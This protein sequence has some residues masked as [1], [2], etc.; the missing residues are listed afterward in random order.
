[1]ILPCVAVDSREDEVFVHGGLAELLFDLRLEDVKFVLH[2]PVNVREALLRCVVVCV[3]P[4]LI[5]KGWDHTVIE[6]LNLRGWIFSTF[7]GGWAFWAHFSHPH[8]LYL[9]L[10]CMM[11]LLGIRR[12]LLR[13]ALLLMSRWGGLSVLL[14]LLL[15]A[16]G[17]LRWCH[18]FCGRF[19][20]MINILPARTAIVIRL[21]ATRNHL[22]VMIVLRLR[23][24]CMMISIH[25]LASLRW[26]LL[27]NLLHLMRLL[28]CTTDRFVPCFAVFWR[29]LLE[30]LLGVI[31]DC[32]VS[33]W[34]LADFPVRHLL[35]LFV[36]GL[37]SFLIK[38][39][40]FLSSSDYFLYDL[41]IFTL[42]LEFA[43]LQP[44]GW[45]IEFRK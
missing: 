10:L 12:G 6:L 37:F 24:N 36:K 3:L 8:V 27:V 15:W 18:L 38:Y 9:L 21:R 42:L 22:V 44:S 14:W 30:K 34:R 33:W 7:I 28:I 11:L 43:R 45:K 39:L 16:A 4:F 2:V 1:M 31:D 32:L 13:R 19:G 17:Y 25:P 20:R 29:L 35:D 23:S 40:L 26:A 41:H 5:S